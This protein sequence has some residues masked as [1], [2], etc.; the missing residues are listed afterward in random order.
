MLFARSLKIMIYS[1]S[2]NGINISLYVRL[3]YGFLSAEFTFAFV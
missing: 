1:D 3:L 2:G